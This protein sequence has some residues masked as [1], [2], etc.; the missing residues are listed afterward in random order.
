V[1]LSALLRQQAFITSYSTGWIQ[2]AQWTRQNVIKETI[3]NGKKQIGLSRQKFEAVQV[4]RDWISV[5]ID[6]R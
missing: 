3:H 5:T 2:V 4:T 1:C 6:D